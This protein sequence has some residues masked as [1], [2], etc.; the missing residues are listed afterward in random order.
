[1][2]KSAPI[3]NGRIWLIGGTQE[4]AQLAAAIAQLKLPCTVTVTTE[5][6]RSLY[7]NAT[8]LCIKVGK[9]SAEQ[10]QQFLQLE[11]IVAIL[12]A[13]HPF[14]VEISKLAIA[15]SLEANLPY[16]RWER[17]ELDPRGVGAGEQ[18]VRG[19]SQKDALSAST[20][21]LCSVSRLYV[22]S[23][24]T[25]LIGNYLL[26]E[27]VLLTVGYRPLVWFQPWQEQAT[28][29]AR[30]LPSVTALEAA[31]AAGFTTDRLLALRP[32]ISLELE[33]ALWQHWQISL[34]VTKAS[35]IAG[36]EDIKHRAAM[37]LGVKLIVVDRPLI[38]YP[39]QTHDLQT[40]LKFCLD[41]L[42][43][44]T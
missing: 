22:D 7:P 2:H 27:R 39:Q 24:E 29:F 44:N 20:E 28:L 6:A 32:P 21:E 5:S 30:V 37:D 41:Y 10:V 15:A 17:L 26:G 43:I 23:F 42:A 35:G 14:A 34:V 19:E 33:K 38:P 25:L 18:R 1:V 3:L 16:L 8:D 4:S 11:Q 31:L 12:D 36:G 9:L 40:A 13:S